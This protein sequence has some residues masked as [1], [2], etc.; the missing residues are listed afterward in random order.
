MGNGNGKNGGALGFALR[1]VFGEVPAQ[2][3]RFVLLGAA[4]ALLYTKAM[5]F[6]RDVTNESVASRKALGEYVASNQAWQ[7]L[8]AET[9]AKLLKQVNRRFQ[10]VY[11]ARGW[12]YED[13]EP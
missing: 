5:D 10:R 12:D 2:W 6:K 1:A 3:I 9:R 4:I 7:N 11:Q 13:I 8:S